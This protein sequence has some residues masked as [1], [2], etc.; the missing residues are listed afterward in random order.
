MYGSMAG[1]LL[2]RTPISHLA[3]L[4]L[5]LVTQS[6]CAKDIPQCLSSPCEEDSPCANEG[7]C[8]RATDPCL[9]NPC[10][11]NATCQVSFNAQTFACQCPTGYGGKNCDIPMERCEQNLC[12][13]GGQCYVS[14]GGLTCVC[15]TGYKGSYCETPTDECLWN[16][17]FN[18]AVCRDKGD[19]RSCYCVPGFQGTLCD[20]EVNECVSQPC[21][22]G[23]TCLNLI[24]RYACVCPAEYTG[25]DCELEVDEC[26]SGP[27]LNDAACHDSL[28]GFSCTCPAGFRGDL[29]QLDVDE[30]ASC[31]CLNGGHCVDGN[32]GYT[33]DCDGVGFIGLHCETPAPLC[34]SQ[35]CHHHATCLED[36]G[37]FTCLCWP[38]VHCEE[39]LNECELNPCQNGGTCENLHGS[40]VCHCAVGGDLA[41]PFYGGRNCGELLI[42]CV[43][44][45]CQNG[46]SCV[47]RLTDGEH[48][49]SC[50]CPAGFRGPECMNRTTFSFNGKAVLPLRNATSQPGHLLYNITLSFQTVQPSAVIFHWGDHETSLRLYL[51]NGS[52]FLA[53]HVN[54]QLKALLHIS[55]HVSDDRWHSVE[56]SLVGTIALKLLDP[57]CAGECVNSSA[58]DVIGGPLDFA[59]Q[60]LIL[61]G[62][63][64]TGT[65]EENGFDNDLQPWLVGCLR[66]V[67]V[68]SAVVTAED[69]TLGNVEVG[70]QRRDLCQSHPCQNRGRCNNLWLS[71]RCDCHRPYRGH[72]CSSEYEAG[73]FGHADLPSYAAFGLG[74]EPS[75]DITI[76]AF[77][78]TRRASGLLLA[79]GNATSYGIAVSLDGGKL[80]VTSSGDLLLTGERVINDGHFH[81][82]SLKMAR[83]R[84]E[85]FLSSQSLGQIS[86]ETQRIQ[87]EDVL[88]V[89]GLQGTGETAKRGGYFKGC[90]QD[91]RMG[92]R[93]LELFP[94][95][96]TTSAGGSRVLSNVTPGCAGDNLCKS[97]PCRNGGVCYSIWDDF[98]CTCPPNTAGQACEDLNWCQLT[99]CPSQAVCQPVPTGYE[100]TADAFFTGTGQ[101]VAYRSNGKITRDLTNLTMGFRTRGT[102]S[103]LLHAEREPESLTVAVRDARLLFH[104]QSGNS[105]YSVSLSG[106]EAVSDGKWHSV[107]WSMAAPGSQAS[108]WQLTTDGQRNVITS[109]VPTGNLNFLR[110]GTDIYLGALSDVTGGGFTGCLGTVEIGGI[111]LPYFAAADYQTVKPQAEQFLKI[112]PGS[113]GVGCLPFNPCASNPC[114]HGGSCQDVYTHPL[115]TCPPG[116]TGARCETDIDECLSSPCLHGNCTDGAAGYWCECQAGYTGANCDIIDSCQ[117]HKCAHGATC[118]GGTTGYSCFCPANFTGRFCSVSSWSE[119]SA[120]SV[121]RI[122]NRMP[123][124]FCG[125]EKRNITCYNYGNCTEVGGEL[126]CVCLTGFVGE[127]CEIDIDECDSDPCLNGGLCQNLPNRYHCLCDMNFAGE[128]CEVDL[129]DFLP[130]GVFTA[131]ASVVLALFFAIC[132][133]LCI[134]IAAAGVRSNQGTYSPSRQEK[135]GSRVEMWDIAQPPPMERLI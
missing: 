10:P 56:V 70:C 1:A 88:Y 25:T 132:A 78:R 7:G 94:K 86:A 61:G 110:E 54:S 84:V 35:P 103:V 28:G 102:E 43:G 29:C 134:F 81:L 96:E 98:T 45:A 48:S 47:P 112:T 125:N 106:A 113:V 129:S 130:S 8:E 108:Q 21:R 23:A 36:S 55:H 33:C 50:Q 52:M 24:G 62:E 69:V 2:T 42:G 31:P 120:L 11:L 91:L 126:R 89:G 87:A 76:S 49:H 4:T 5:L 85:L 119:A 95:S 12:R 57:S 9:S 117:S 37:S 58:H 111:P 92:S 93:R 131:V 65:Q 41:G 18:G 75:D 90:V 135:E 53:S 114:T 116:R 13:H 17:C 124:T 80:T 16:P 74:A 97:S 20:I 72:N 101:G 71:Y 128:R 14:H 19:G 34:W 26:S 39:D 15:A 100:C 127:R 115:C 46:G 123:S 99:P 22:N 30:C 104:L 133:G 105:F 82:V 68:N 66:D 63:P 118:I 67:G 44:R 51:Q 6:L 107:T 60:N 122:F 79:L 38:G 83:H 59:F 40:Y 32:N 73:R 27:C 64:S 77:M 121:V 3:A 109:S